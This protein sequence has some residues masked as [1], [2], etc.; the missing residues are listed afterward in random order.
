[1][2]KYNQLAHDIQNQLIRWRRDLHG[3]PE[4]GLYLPET[5]KYLIKELR[6]MGL[7]VG[8]DKSCSG[9]TATI[10]VSEN[11]MGTNQK[12]I[13]IRADMDALPI[14][15][16]T[17]LS[18]AP[19][20]KG[21]MHACGHDAHMAIALG[22]ARLL[23][24]NKNDLKGSVKM[25]FQ[26][27]EED[28]GGAKLMIENGVLKNVDS[29]IG[30]HIGIFDELKSGQIG[31]AYIPSMACLDR[32]TITVHGKG[33]HGGMPHASVDP[34]VI[35]ASIIQELQTLISRELSPTHAG[36]I[37]IGLIEGGSSYNIIPERVLMKGTAR[38]IDDE[39]RIRISARMKQLTEMVAEAKLGK[40]EFEY[41]YG[42]PPVVNN[43]EFTDI[44]EKSAKCIV[45][46]SNIVRI[47]KPTMAGE[48]MAFFL[49][50]VPGTYFFL[51][52]LKEYQHHHPKFDIEEDVLPIGTAVLV[53]MVVKWLDRQSRQ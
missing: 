5:Q 23:S 24:E 19:K 30:F 17:G 10:D 33:S 39:D 45:G 34:V 25:I 13:A 26:P 4:T 8:F 27:G 9:L 2:N 14:E 49:N 52:G 15:E 35:S 28:P 42:Y 20:E 53:D 51:G 22:A 40:A 50:E 43:L 21:K 41:V 46:E 37:S 6:N 31:V 36:V 29:I 38:F 48:D 11:G 18:F 1:M 32:F 7:D 47:Q 3:I 44:F 16:E 12:T